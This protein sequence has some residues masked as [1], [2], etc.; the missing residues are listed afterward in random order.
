MKHAYIASYNDV[1]AAYIERFVQIPLIPLKTKT[2]FV[3]ENL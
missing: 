1:Q 3:L 2:F